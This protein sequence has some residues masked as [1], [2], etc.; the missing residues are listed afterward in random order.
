MVIETVDSFHGKQMDV[1][2]MSCVR[3]SEPSLQSGIGFVADIR[4]MNVAITRAKQALWILG[5]A[6]TL[7]VLPMQ[8]PPLLSCMAADRPK[9]TGKTFVTWP[10]PR[11]LL[12]RA[13]RM[14]SIT[15]WEVMLD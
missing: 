1:V 5:S 4:C 3:A 13:S 14:C 15:N 11:G 2:I 9:V 8:E 12:Y 10:R 7:T 6:A